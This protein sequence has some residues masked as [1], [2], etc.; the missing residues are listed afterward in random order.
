MSKA[1]NISSKSNIIVTYI[2]ICTFFKIDRI[3][4]EP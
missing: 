1:S 2:K 3:E 4:R